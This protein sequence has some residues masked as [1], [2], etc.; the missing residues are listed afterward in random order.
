MKNKEWLHELFQLH[1]QEST[2]EQSKKELDELEKMLEAAIIKNKQQPQ[3]DWDRIQEAK[4]LNELKGKQTAH[5]R[6]FSLKSY[7][8]NDQQ[9]KD[10]F[11]TYLQNKGYSID[12]TEETYKSDVTA[13][14]DGKTSLF[15]LEVSSVDFDKNNW[16]Y[17]FIHF[18]GRKERYYKEQGNFHY[19]IISKNGKYA[20][21]AQAK[22]IFKKEN[23][24]TK[25]CNR[26]GVTGVDEFFKLEPQEVKFFKL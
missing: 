5:I 3:S 4:T 12:S 14:K 25:E 23:Y 21:T 18:L 24:I 2:E 13:S 20:L 10:L 22:D 15:E 19:V 1:K 8:T 26:G 11:T 7:L 6:D 9:A 17:Q 16:P